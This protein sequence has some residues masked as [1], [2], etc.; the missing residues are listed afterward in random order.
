[1]HGVTERLV[2]S[3]PPVCGVWAHRML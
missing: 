2:A 3:P 1:M